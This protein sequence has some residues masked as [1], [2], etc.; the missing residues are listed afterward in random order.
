MENCNSSYKKMLLLDDK[1][2][3]TNLLLSNDLNKINTE[4]DEYNKICSHL[5]LCIQEILKVENR[6]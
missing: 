3:K 1:V 5:K 2:K 4:L 6:K